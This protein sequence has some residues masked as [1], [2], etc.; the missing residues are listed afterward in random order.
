MKI[1]LKDRLKAYIRKNYPREFAKGDIDQIVRLHTNYTVENTGRRLRELQNDGV[2]EVRYGNKN[3]A[4][5]KATEP[6]RVE[7]YK[8]PA[9]GEVINKPIWE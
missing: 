7:T 3:H 4:Y 5:Y 2:I 8:I 9:T 1:S 6:L